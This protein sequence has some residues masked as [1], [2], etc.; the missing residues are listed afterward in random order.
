M[1]ER[2]AKTTRQ[3]G[4]NRSR[5]RWVRVRVQT[6]E[7]PLVG[8]VR[9]EGARSSLYELVDD[10]RA[11]LGVW[12]ARRTE[13]SP[14]EEFVAIHKSAIRSVVLDIVGDPEADGETEEEG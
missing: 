14:S 13:S 6:D 12:D 3:N 11:Y 4:A 7:G 1:D 10:G 2:R 8:N 5:P 9:L